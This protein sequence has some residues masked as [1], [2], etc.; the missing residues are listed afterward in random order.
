MATEK[1]NG[2]PVYLFHFN[3]GYKSKNGISVYIIRFCLWLQEQKKEFRYISSI[4]VYG[5]KEIWWYS[6]LYLPFLSMATKKYNGISGFIFHFVYD[7]K[8]K[9]ML[10]LA[11]SSILS[12][13]TRAKKRSSCLYLIYLSMAT[14]NYDGIPV[15]I[16]HFCLWLQRIIMVFRSIIS[17]ILSMAT[18]KYNGI[19]VFIFHF[20]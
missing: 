19:S 13:A 20:I 3:Y 17:S 10:F 14:K 16:F 5:Y 7:Y 11:I 1:Y 4:F 12:M 15:F 9:K 2:I 18:K 6:G 8:S